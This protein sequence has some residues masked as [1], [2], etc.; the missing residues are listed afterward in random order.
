MIRF[1]RGGPFRCALVV[2]SGDAVDDEL[3]GELASRTG[4]TFHEAG[5]GGFGGGPVADVYVDESGD[6]VL[7][8]A[9]DPDTGVKAF[10]VRAASADQAVAVRDVIGD[11]FAVWTE[12]TLRAQLADTLAEQPWTLVPLMMAVG[13][14]EPE[15]ATLELLDSGLRHEDEEVRAA[16]GHAE[17]LAKE[18]LDDPAVLPDVPV[19]ELKPVLRPTRPVEGAEY[20]VTVRPG[21]PERAVPRPVTWLRLP[22]GVVDPLP[23][24]T[25]DEDWFLEVASPTTDVFQE[26]IWTDEN[27]RTALHDVTHHELAGRYFA[28]HGDDTETVTA[29]LRQAGVQ[30]LDG[31]PEGLARTAP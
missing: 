28:V 10:L 16:A 17:A 6:T 19:S 24:F 18:L 25:W 2:R 11:R 27:G 4:M 23:D 5:N 31:P 26:E 13:G 21:V 30:L 8:E 22:A 12:Q 20:W 7:I 29:T 15:P 14:A 9:V 1:V 3:L